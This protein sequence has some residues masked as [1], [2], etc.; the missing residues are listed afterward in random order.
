MTNSIRS[1]KVLA[2]DSSS[3]PDKASERVADGEAHWNAGRQK[4]LVAVQLRS[5]LWRRETQT[6][7]F[8][9]VAWSLVVAMVD[10]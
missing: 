10:H 5:E 4:E 9:R 8:A 1:I 6:I 3:L 7:S 2:M